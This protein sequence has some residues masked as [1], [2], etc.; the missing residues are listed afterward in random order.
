MNVL[1]SPTLKA[2]NTR[3]RQEIIKLLSKRPYTASELSKLLGK[4]V[5]TVSEHLNV[6]EKSQLVQRKEGNKW[7]YYNLTPKAQNLSKPQYSWSILFS[8]FISLIAGSYLYIIGT[9][10]Q[11]LAEGLKTTAPALTTDA[12]EI[13]AV[14]ENIISIDLIFGTAL[15][16]LGVV[17]LAF[18]AAKHL[19]ARTLTKRSLYIE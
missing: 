7:I 9:E 14:T 11:F 18:V 17:G 5:T 13:A 15:I 3:T 1:D 6:L 19:R 8:S 2:L 12:P 4:H 10:P 16:L